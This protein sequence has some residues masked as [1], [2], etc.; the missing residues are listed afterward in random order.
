MLGL[1]P[2]FIYFSNSLALIITSKSIFVFQMLMQPCTQV[3]VAEIKMRVLSQE[4]EQVVFLVLGVG[5]SWEVHV[6][7]L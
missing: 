5:E 3:M 7:S 6:L 4:T 2:A 1:W